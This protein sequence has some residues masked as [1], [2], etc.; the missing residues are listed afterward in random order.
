MNSN[1]DTLK[2]IQEITEGPDLTLGNIV[3]AIRQGENWTQAELARK[4]GVSRQFVCDLEHGRRIISPKMAECIALKLG[5]SPR[6]FIR[7]CIQ[8]TF[9]KQGLRY[10]VDLQVA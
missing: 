1:K 4:L 3:S 8:D 10:K 6:Q 9:I 7:F 5:Y 2:E